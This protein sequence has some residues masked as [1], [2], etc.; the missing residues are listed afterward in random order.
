MAACGA[1]LTLHQ[2]P[3]AQA[4][5]REYGFGRFSMDLDGKSLQVDLARDFRIPDA[6]SRI[7][8]LLALLD[9]EREIQLR[10]DRA[11][12][13]G[14]WELTGAILRMRKGLRVIL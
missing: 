8:S 2:W 13:E 3:E 6:D 5:F 1:G 14:E 11:E 7:L 10:T 9:P 4:S 12:P